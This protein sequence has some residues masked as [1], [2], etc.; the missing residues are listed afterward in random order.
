MMTHELNILETYVS[1]A[2]M[3]N[4]NAY[5]RQISET[6]KWLWHF[7]HKLEG[8]LLS[9]MSHLRHWWVLSESCQRK[10]LKKKVSHFISNLIHFLLK[11]NL[12]YF[13]VIFI[14]L[15]FTH[16][17]ENCIYRISI[18]Q[19]IVKWCSTFYTILEIAVLLLLSLFLKN[20]YYSWQ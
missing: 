8:D 14:N 18:V 9:E 16:L 15:E 2:T 17:K 19:N 1:R 4:W 3:C 13:K 6:Q 11:I 20:Y 5:S 7:M 12:K 10:A